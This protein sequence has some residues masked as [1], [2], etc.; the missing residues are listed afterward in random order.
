MVDDA[1]NPSTWRLRQNCEFEA[2]LCDI[3][4]PSQKEKEKKKKKR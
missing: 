2:S 1:C 3:V 4:R